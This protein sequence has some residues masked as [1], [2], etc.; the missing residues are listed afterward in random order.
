[1]NLHRS[2][3]LVKNKSIILENLKQAK[4]YLTTDKISQEDLTNIV[5]AD[6]TP[7]KKYVGWMAKI[8]IQ[9]KTDIDDLRN[10]VEE[11]NT[12]LNKGKTKTKDINTF[13]SFKDLKSE[14]DNLNNSG[15]GISIGDSENDYE[16]IIN[17]S[18]LLIICPH[19][20]EASRK[21]GLSKFAFRDCKGGG[22]DSAW[23]TTYK[24]PDHFNDYYYKNN[25][26][27]YY[28]RVKS[29]EMIDKL[30]EAFPGQHK[31]DK[32]L[33]RYKAMEVTALAVLS[34][35]KR[36]GQIDGYDGLDDQINKKDI[37]IYINILGIS[38]ILIPRRPAEEREKNYG[39]II[40]K[41]IQQ[42]MKDGGKGDLEL[43]NSPITSLP[44][45]L[46]VG[47]SLN[48]QNSKITSLP[49]GLSV[50]GELNLGNSSIISLPADL[51]VGG[52]LFLNHIKI[53]SLPADLSVG[54]SLY[55]N[56]LPITSLPDGLSVNGDLDL[57]GI[58]ITSLPNNL[59]VRGYL[60]LSG[61]PIEE[62]PN[63][64][65][66][67]GIFY[68]YDTPISKKYTKDQLKRMLP[69]VKGNIMLKK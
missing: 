13:K 20:H 46:S 69:G 11:F 37:S 39:I 56:N 1:M 41:K 33:E 4:S 54:G 26:T 32:K 62:L 19:T 48:L 22:K 49:T 68:L 21:L 23:C 60:N 34:D 35:N 14:I 28:I 16:V 59:S 38:N 10:T 8:F 53:K 47:G 43:P 2:L 5:N 63:N 50:G 65:S 17:N 44:D 57:K 18:D 42:Y 45:G 9:D 6:P 55:L 27:F 66:V 58:K 61:L 29:P 24:A 15:E 3:L 40:Q 30:K 12:F 36:S 7:Q 51:S 52:S 64:L 67:G 31:K 25:V